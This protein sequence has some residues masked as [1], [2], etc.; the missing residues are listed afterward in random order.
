[1]TTKRYREIFG[2]DVRDLTDQ[3]IETKMAADSPF[4]G[5]LTDLFEDYL[6]TFKKSPMM[7]VG[8]GKKSGLIL[9]S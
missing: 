1:M 9:A 6:T 5:V 7:E 2:N 8:H 3:E 4:V